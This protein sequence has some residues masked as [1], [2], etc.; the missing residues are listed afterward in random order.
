VAEDKGFSEQRVEKIATAYEQT[1]LDRLDKLVLRFA[2]CF[3]TQPAGID[4]SLKAEMRAHFSADMRAHFSDEAIV[5]ITA[6]LGLFLGFSKIAIALGP[7][8]DGLPVMQ[9]PLPDLPAA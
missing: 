8:P 9:M 6:A 3:L 7:L 4:E 1:D 2:D 5:E